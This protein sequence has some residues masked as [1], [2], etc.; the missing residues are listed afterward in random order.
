MGTL[1]HSETR[2]RWQGW[3]QTLAFLGAL[4]ILVVVFYTSSVVQKEHKADERKKATAAV[5][6]T[7][8]WATGQAELRTGAVE[9]GMSQRTIEAIVLPAQQTVAAAERLARQSTPVAVSGEALSPENADRIEALARWG[10]GILQAAAFSPDGRLLAVGTTVGVDLYGWPVQG[11]PRNFDTGVGVYYL[12]FS[13]DGQTL[14]VLLANWTVQIWQL[15]QGTLLRTVEGLPGQV[16]WLTWSQQGLLL[17]GRRPAD[18]SVWLWQE[19]TGLLFRLP[20]QPETDVESLD[21]SPSG[22]V[23][24]V[25]RRDGTVELRQTDDGSLLRTFAVDGQVDQLRFSPDGELLAAAFD[26]G[27]VQLWRVGDGTLLNTLDQDISGS[28]VLFS[29]DGQLLLSGGRSALGLWSVPDG[30]LKQTIELPFGVFW[31]LQ[32]IAFSPDGKAAAVTDPD[33]GQ[34]HLWQTITGQP[35][36]SLAGYSDS[37]LQIGF[38]P[39]GQQLIANESWRTIWLW[40][41]ASGTPRAVQGGTW[42]YLPP[43]LAATFSPDNSMVS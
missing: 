23:V 19:G 10:R 35:L 30:L 25:K 13:P 4:A 16:R 2:Q 29:A 6:A 27:T 1:D 17:A 5:E 38:S 3:L 31:H 33:H 36:P 8:A 24:A 7:A 28:G 14:A 34:V 26:R 41:V 21:F 15:D 42:D 20:T 40:Q 22:K 39:D 9:T 37:V 43:M 32:P 12:A 18:E 11:Q